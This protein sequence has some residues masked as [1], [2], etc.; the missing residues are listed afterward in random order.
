MG[1][2][3]PHSQR[4]GIGMALAEVNGVLGNVPEGTHY[5][6]VSIQAFKTGIWFPGCP[7]WPSVLPFACL[8]PNFPSQGK[9]WK[10]VDGEGLGTEWDKP[11]LVSKLGGG[12]GT[13]PFHLIY[14]GKPSE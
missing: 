13:L 1:G 2:R 5:V 9:D 3:D 12:V 8:M 4:G 14:Q 11:A 7:I 6:C 10:G